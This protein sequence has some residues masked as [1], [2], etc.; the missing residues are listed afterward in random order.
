MKNKIKSVL[1]VL[2]AISLLSLVSCSRID[3]G[4]VGM[5]VSYF[6]DDKGVNDIVYVTGWTFYNPLTSTV[7]E[8]PTFVRHVEYTGEHGFVVNSKDG[9]EFAVNPIINYSIV[10]DKAPDIY[11]KYRKDLE[12]LEIAFLK[13]TVQDVFRVAANEFNAD[14]LISNRQRF[15]TLVM[16]DLHS[17]LTSEGFMVQQLTSNLVYPESFKNAINAKN[18]AVQQALQAENQVKTAEAQ[19]KIKVAQADGEAQAMLTTARAE[20]EAN[21]LRQTTLT[22]NLLQ[23]QFINKWDGVLPVYG[24]VPTLFKSIQ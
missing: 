23:Q 13:T 6:G 24:Q 7:I 4:H 16:K 19:A 8:W 9:S 17:R 2:G 3:A 22:E 21:R 14:S 15:E 11:R 5:K 12:D 1:M 10:P 18:N 20:A